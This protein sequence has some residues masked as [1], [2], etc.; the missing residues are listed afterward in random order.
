MLCYRGQL[1]K[2]GCT[3]EVASNGL[4]AVDKMSRV[5]VTRTVSP[6]D[7]DA[8]FAG[9]AVTNLGGLTFILSSLTKFE[10]CGDCD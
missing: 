7:I 2:L 3:V 9:L 5:V 6:S 10:C 4:I 1:T 8:G